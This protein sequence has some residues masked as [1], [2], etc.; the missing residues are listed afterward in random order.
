ERAE[1]LVTFSIYFVDVLDLNCL[2]AFFKSNFGMLT[3]DNLDFL[4]SQTMTEL[5]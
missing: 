1:G 5:H 2:E 3:K 4:Y